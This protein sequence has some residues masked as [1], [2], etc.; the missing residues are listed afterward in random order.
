[1]KIE[2]IRSDEFGDLYVDYYEETRISI[3]IYT[4]GSVTC[5]SPRID[6]LNQYLKSEQYMCMIQTVLNYHVL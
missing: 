6:V 3:R 4:D 1:M 5:Y 2:L